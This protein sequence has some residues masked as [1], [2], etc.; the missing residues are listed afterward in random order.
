MVLHAATVKED[1]SH[2]QKF[3]ESFKEKYQL[4]FSPGHNC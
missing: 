3:I 4:G 2:L 1:A